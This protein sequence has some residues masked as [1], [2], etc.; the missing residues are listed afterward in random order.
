MCGTEREERKEGTRSTLT[1][2]IRFTAGDKWPREDG[3]FWGVSGERGLVLRALVT[4]CVCHLEYKH[5]SLDNL[6]LPKYLEAN[7]RKELAG[8]VWT[9]L[10]GTFINGWGTGRREG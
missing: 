5:T 3:V 6:L 2:L 1:Q 7:W 8:L 9:G 4:R 10:L